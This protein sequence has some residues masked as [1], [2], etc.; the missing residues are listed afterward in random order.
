VSDNIF[1]QVRTESELSILRTELEKIGIT[2]AGLSANWR[3]YNEEFCVRLNG[4]TLNYAYRLFY[5]TQYPG[6]E[7][8]T[9]FQ[10]LKRYKIKHTSDNLNKEMVKAIKEAMERIHAHKHD[11]K[12]G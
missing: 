4:N 5:E 12:L 10:Y 9:V 11:I 8:L 3:S 7:I 1:I 6:C 2:N